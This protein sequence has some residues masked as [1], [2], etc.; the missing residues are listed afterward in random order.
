ME[1]VAEI[2]GAG[3]LSPL[4]KWRASSVLVCLHPSGKGC[5]K[6]GVKNYLFGQ[7]SVSLQE[8]TCLLILQIHETTA[9]WKLHALLALL[10]PNEL[11]CGRTFSFYRHVEKQGM[12]R[13]R[14]AG[15]RP[16]A[17]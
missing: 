16:G 15:K 13:S 8:P 2:W 7:E 14:C 12:N 4:A 3:N 10:V 11:K 5:A 6:P 9:A 17:V 1:A